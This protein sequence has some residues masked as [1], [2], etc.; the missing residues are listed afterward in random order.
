MT[1][2][3]NALNDLIYDAV[4]AVAPEATVT[5]RRE[6]FIGTGQAVYVRHR[7]AES[8]RHLL[9]DGSNEAFN[10]IVEISVY[11]SDPDSAVSQAADIA[12]AVMSVLKNEFFRLDTYDPV[13]N[14]DPTIYR[15]EMRFERYIGSGDEMV[16]EP[17]TEATT[18]QENTP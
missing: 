5:T 15:L 1:Y 12:G 16:T 7:H 9:L 13:D 18:E 17:T 11:T 4:I 10:W 14:I 6:P 8:R 3:E 2:S